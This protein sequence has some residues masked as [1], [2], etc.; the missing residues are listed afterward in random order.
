MQNNIRGSNKTR[1]KIYGDKTT[2]NCKRLC[3]II[4]GE[5]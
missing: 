1:Y 5:T 2:R 3:K 4:D